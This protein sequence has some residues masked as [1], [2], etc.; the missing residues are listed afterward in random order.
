VGSD[1]SAPTDPGPPTALA[2]VEDACRRVSER[3]AFI[4]VL[5]IL[6][7]ALMIVTDVLLR[8]LFS[9]PI[10]GM[11]EVID[12]MLAAAISAVF[13]AGVCRRVH[14]S[15]DLLA[16]QL[17][18]KLVDWL[19]VAGDV[20]LF[21][22]LVVFS[23]SM[24]SYAMDLAARGAK[25]PYLGVPTA[26]T[27]GFVGLLFG[28]SALLQVVM[29]A[30][31]I[32]AVQR[33]SP[34]GWG[35]ALAGLVVIALVAVAVAYGFGALAQARQNAWLTLSIFTLLWAIAFLLVPLGAT[36]ALLGL[37][38][39]ALLI[40]GE[41]AIAM[42]GSE[43]ASFLS[44]PNVATLPLFLLM[45]SFAAV[46]GVA[47][48][49]YRLAQAVLGRFRG[50]LAHATIGAC[51]GFG[52]V[53]GSSLATAATI[54]RAVVPEMRAR[55]YGP[56]LITGSVAAG[57][58]L[59]ALVP[60]GSGPLVVFA[61]LTEASIGQL[62][63]ASVGPAL[64]IVLLYLATVTLIVRFQPSY[65]PAGRKPQKGELVHALGR[66][67]AILALFLVVMGGLYLGVF[68]ATE[69]AAVGACGAFLVALWRGK[70]RKG[71]LWGVMAETTE[72]TAM[73]YVLIFGA[74]MFSFF[75]GM[76][77]VIE[78]AA[79]YVT[80]LR[81]DPIVV[82]VLLLF[83]Y[84]LLG[85][86]MDGFTIM[87]ITVPIVT[88]LILGMNYSLVWWGIIMLIVVEAGNISPPFGLNMFVLKTLMPDMPMSVVFRGVVPF[89]CA[90]LVALALCTAFPSIALWLVA[91]M[92]K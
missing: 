89:F 83:L 73:I 12:I 23:W 48:D 9:A 49:V 31:R 14:L 77:G 20:V 66:S 42:A 90:L 26:P 61:L 30:R 17:P 87:I 85:T 72:T 67:G 52:A 10:R 27:T 46:A 4:G 53:T 39:T 91:T 44:N 50:G 3:L 13:P 68:T 8:W 18:P 76:S 2:R 33:R 92:P 75:V 55:G 29:I 22:L 69:S 6:A 56:P 43:I 32:Q 25:T 60:P 71:A 41:Q 5:G 19:T 1:S 40:G 59:G 47:E 78:T 37:S 51:A 81:W 88:P 35:R 11:N 15:I 45:G 79:G 21:I 36:M 62:F 63:I 57:G 38:G 86:F 64:L 82:V 65:A 16:P 54:G 80:Q 24:A 28:V 74:L 84:I 70:L 58:T 34:I 7:I